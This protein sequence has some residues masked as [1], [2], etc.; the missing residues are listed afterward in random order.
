MQR[1]RRVARQSRPLESSR[2][3]WGWLRRSRPG[4]AGLGSWHR[5]AGFVAP[6]PPGW[7]HGAAAASQCSPQL[8][9]RRKG[10]ETAERAKKSLPTTLIARKSLHRRSG[11]TGKTS[12]RPHRRTPGCGGAGVQHGSRATESAAA[13]SQGSPQLPHR[14]KGGE[15]AERAKKSLPT[16]QIARKSLHRRSGTTGKTSI[17]QHRRTPGCGGAGVQHGARA[18]ES[19]AATSQGSPQLPHRK[20]GGETAERAKK[21]LPAT[22]IARKSLL[23]GGW[24]GRPRSG[25]STTRNAWRTAHGAWRTAHGAWRMA[26]GADGADGGRRGRRGTHSARHTARNPMLTTHN[27]HRGWPPTD[28]AGDLPRRS[29]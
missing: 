29:D 7:I 13:A 15:T 23:R 11:T 14:R 4:T 20:K 21:S 1:C 17:R 19:A 28:R 5:R 2:R 6:P 24:R 26:D 8:P 18:T 27:P 10:G 9:H 16:T 22:Q 12:I 3:R 25:A